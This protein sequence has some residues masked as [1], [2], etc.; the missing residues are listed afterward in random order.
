LQGARYA[1]YLGQSRPL[2]YKVRTTH[3]SSSPT[4]GANSGAGSS[5]SLV[6]PY[7]ITE[8]PMPPIKTESARQRQL[9]Q[10]RVTLEYPM[11][12]DNSR[13]TPL[14][15]SERSQTNTSTDETLDLPKEYKFFGALRKPCVSIALSLWFLLH[16][17]GGIERWLLDI[18]CLNSQNSILYRE[19]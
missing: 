6:L 12:F 19:P 10:A 14:N 13:W 16:H 8:G 5:S 15:L 4:L 2:T 17:S 11:V 9:E 7:D 1:G 18:T 3:R